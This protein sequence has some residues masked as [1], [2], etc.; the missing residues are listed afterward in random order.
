MA[1]SAR[2]SVKKTNRARLKS[3]VFGPAEDARTK[4]LSE[5][6]AAIASTT[7]MDTEKES[8]E[9]TCLQEYLHQ[10]LTGIHTEA[11]EPVQESK[12]NSGDT[13]GAS[14]SSL[15]IPIPRA[16]F[17]A[18]TCHLPLTPPPT[19]PATHAVPVASSDEDEDVHP[20]ESFFFHLLG[21]A[22]DITHFDDLGNLVLEF[23]PAT[24]NGHG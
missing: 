24:R 14:R 11:A 12:E 4:R 5:K 17:A 18:K 8:S 3:R 2:S 16:M 1:K 19:P 15:S 20:D 9:N 10:S 7:P 22:A 6:L 21:V 23:D 13:Q